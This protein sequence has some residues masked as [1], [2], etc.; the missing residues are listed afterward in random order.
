LCRFQRI[1]PTK[2]SHSYFKY[3]DKPRYY[4]LL[5]SAW[6]QRYLTFIIYQ[7]SQA[8]LIVNK[9]FDESSQ[10]LIMCAH[11]LMLEGSSI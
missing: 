7:M 11:Q 6:E 4:N 5:L 8:F 3:L 2:E 9:Y 1:F 10:L